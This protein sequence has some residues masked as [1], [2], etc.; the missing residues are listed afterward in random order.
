MGII[1]GAVPTPLCR[2]SDINARAATGFVIGTAAPT[3]ATCLRKVLR[4]VKPRTIGPPLYFPLYFW[5]IGVAEIHRSL[6]SRFLGVSSLL[7]RPA[8]RAASRL[9]VTPLNRR[10]VGARKKERI[11][12][13]WECQR[14]SSQ[15]DPSYGRCARKSCG[16]VVARP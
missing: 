9:R 10:P 15:S 8:P 6:R 7:N 4:L 5:E 2:S 11:W 1:S 16:R 12:S 3:E 13:D 14:S